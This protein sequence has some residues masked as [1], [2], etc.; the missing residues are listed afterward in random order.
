MEDD[1]FGFEL[2]HSQYKDKLNKKE[3]LIVLLIHWYLTKNKFRCLGIGDS[4][5]CNPEENGSELLPEGWSQNTNYSLRYIRNKELYILIIL[6]SEKN[7]LLNFLKVA[8]HSVANSEIC[9]DAVESLNGN[10]E[11]MI[12]S[13]K[14]IIKSLKND[15]PIISSVTTSEMSVQTAVNETRESNIESR[16]RDEGA[17]SSLRMPRLPTNNPL[18]IG[19]DDL[20]IF[21]GGN[22]GMLFD[23][24]QNQ[25]QRDRIPPSLGIPGQLPRGAVP[26]GARFDHF[27]PIDYD[28]NRSRFRAPDGDFPPPDYEN[29]FL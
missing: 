17:P 22:S 20:N 19:S 2:L 26:P 13:H 14:N 18:A 11:T 21:G 6:K 4:K 23:P 1:F 27:G 16:L 29:M 8:D 25:R 15:I 12:P 24:F 7:L 3:D 9:I 28:M 10:L 5:E